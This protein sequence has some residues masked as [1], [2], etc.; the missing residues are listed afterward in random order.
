MAE[1]ALICN[2]ALVTGNVA[3]KGS[4]IIALR[5]YGNS[6]GQIDMGVSSEYLPGQER[7][8][9]ATPRERL[10]ELWGKTMPNLK[11]MNAE[12]M[13]QK[14]SAGKIRGI[15]AI[16]AG[17]DDINIEHIGSS[18]AFSVLISPVFTE[19]MQQADVILP[20]TT[21][22]ETEGTFTSA[23]LRVQRL[24]RAI[25]PESGKQTWQILIELS[26]ALGYEMDYKGVPE[27]FRE[28]TRAVPDYSHLAFERIPEGGIRLSTCDENTTF[29]S[30]LWLEGM[31]EF[32]AKGKQ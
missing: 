3:R 17:N 29:I 28:I 30:P 27:I 6:Q 2:L 14:A 5:R 11:G 1:L 12:E 26:Q 24:H 7:V 13:V 20:G 9:D 15:I 25:Q 22:A 23:E 32:R 31:T 18:R 4:G 19:E 10:K 16:G 8:F 21:F